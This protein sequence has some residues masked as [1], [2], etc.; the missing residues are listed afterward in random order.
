MGDGSHWD[1]SEV[2][3]VLGGGAARSA[4]EVAFALETDGAELEGEDVAPG[5]VVVGGFA[6][7]LAGAFGK[8]A[9]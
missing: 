6:T 2:K 9:L 8:F 1:G 7:D 5:G 4:S 3:G